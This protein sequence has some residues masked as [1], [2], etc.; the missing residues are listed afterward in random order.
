ML[1]YNVPQNSLWG[2]W[3][4]QQNTNPL[5]MPVHQAVETLLPSGHAGPTAKMSPLNQGKLLVEKSYDFK[6]L[7]LVIRV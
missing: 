7:M 3:W 4:W 6:A 5:K 1:E 2:I